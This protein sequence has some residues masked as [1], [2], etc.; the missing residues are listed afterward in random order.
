MSGQHVTQM[1]QQVAAARHEAAEVR[2]QAGK[3]GLGPA[4]QGAGWSRGNW[5]A[6]QLATCH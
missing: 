6:Q 3:V 2:A 5:T 1:E 4:R